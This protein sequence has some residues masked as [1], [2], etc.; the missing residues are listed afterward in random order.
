MGFGKS[1]NF[2]NAKQAHYLDFPYYQVGLYFSMTKYYKSYVLLSS[3]R[4]KFP[5]DDLL[6]II[7]GY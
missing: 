5:L 3:I 6:Q 2:T 4:P 7:G 1:D